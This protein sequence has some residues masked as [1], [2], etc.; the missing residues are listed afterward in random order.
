VLCEYVEDITVV[1]ATGLR[2][3]QLK[4]RDHGSWSAS[5]MCD[6]GIKSLVRSY[7]ECRRA[8]LHERSTFELWL[9]GATADAPDTKDF[10]DDPTTALP[11]IR[12]K[13]LSAGLA[14]NCLVDFL[15]RLVVRGDQPSRPYIDAQ[16]LHELG[17]LW[18][19][20]S[21]PE[22]EQIYTRLLDSVTA[23]QEAAPQ[24]AMI[25]NHLAA[26]NF[27]GA[28]PVQALGEEVLGPLG[29]QVL[30]REVLVAVTPPR[31]EDSDEMLARMAAG[32]ST[33]RLEL[34]MLR[35]GASSKTIQ[36]A[37]ELRAEMEVQRQLMMASRE[38]ADPELDKLAGRLLTMAQATARR[39][40]L[41]AASTPAAAV[42]SAEAITDDLLS[43]PQDLAYCDRAG[44]FEQDSELLYGYLGHLSDLCRF[45][46]R[47]E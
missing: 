4:T 41:S 3:M 37:K 8:G 9:E 20:L 44:I 1:H 14:R 13:I 22:R 45:A 7:T 42:R 6:K 31:P 24:P 19:A 47:A 2:F 5:M 17:R 29:R 21:Q 35:A 26:L 40:A 39:I 43:R 10:V 23:A 27:D 30:N 11:S 12:E 15:Q 33:S 34:K 32:G 28:R 16:V 18:P 46:W 38:S 36:R 25:G